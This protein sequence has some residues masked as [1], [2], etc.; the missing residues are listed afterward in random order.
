M[1]MKILIEIFFS[2]FFQT[3]VHVGEETVETPIF[4]QLDSSVCHLAVERY[5]LLL[6]NIS[7]KTKPCTSICNCRFSR[8]ALIGRST[9][10]GWGVKSL[11]L[12]PFL[13]CSPLAPQECSVRLYCLEDTQAS[14]Q[15]VVATERKLGGR[16]LEHPTAFLF[17]DGGGGLHVSLDDPVGKFSR[18]FSFQ[19]ISLKVGGNWN[20][21]ICYY[22]LSSKQSLYVSREIN[23]KCASS[24][25]E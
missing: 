6:V 14:L 20:Y 9:P 11:R 13:S 3:V 10:S 21:S 7:K 23:R 12:A 4:A 19:R 22:C 1:Q 15:G 25:G 8:Y 18:R 24:G 5:V 17:Q 16:L 2:L